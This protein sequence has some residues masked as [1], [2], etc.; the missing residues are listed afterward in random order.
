MLVLPRLPPPSPLLF[1]IELAPVLKRW[2]DVD[3]DLDLNESGVESGVYDSRNAEPNADFDRADIMVDDDDDFRRR[4]DEM[5]DLFAF[6][7]AV[8]GV[9][10]VRSNNNRAAGVRD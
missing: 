1:R 7:L 3:L 10:V 6:A 9:V 8:A 5:E 4:C 2:C